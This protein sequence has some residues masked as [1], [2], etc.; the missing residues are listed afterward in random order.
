MACTGFKKEQSDFTNKAHL[1]ARKLIYPKFFNTENNKHISLNYRDTQVN[2]SDKEGQFLDGEWGIDRIIQVKDDR[3]NAPFEFTFQ[4]R[5]RTPDKQVFQDLTVTSWN[6]ASNLP[7]ELYKIK[8]HYFLYGY[9]NESNNSFLEAIIIDVA[10]FLHN[11]A[12]NNLQYKADKGNDRGQDFITIPFLEL[13]N[14]NIITFHYSPYSFKFYGNLSNSVVS[15]NNLSSSIKGLKEVMINRVVDNLE[16]IDTKLDYI[17]K[18]TQ[19]DS[20]IGV[21]FPEDPNNIVIL[22][23]KK[24]KE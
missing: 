7:S 15:L 11:I 5:F 4:E 6:N 9:F 16:A 19:Y 23:G 10:R 2:G 1:I 3:H 17:I 20:E 13:F 22:K 12:C 8:A 21:R 18:N 14:K 24:V